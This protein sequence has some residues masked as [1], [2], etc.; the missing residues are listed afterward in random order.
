[1]TTFDLLLLSTKDGLVVRKVLKSVYIVIECP[2]IL[3]LLFDF[4]VGFNK[5]VVHP[6]TDLVVLV[7]FRFKTEVDK[8]LEIISISNALE[9]PIISNPQI[10]IK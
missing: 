2:R 8:M 4:L 9:H 5:M 1:M 6:Q 7:D 10:L 3:N